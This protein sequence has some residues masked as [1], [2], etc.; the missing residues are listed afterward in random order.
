MGRDKARLRVD[1]EPLWRRQVRVLRDAGAGPVV[2]VQALGQRALTRQRNVRVLRDI[3]KNAG[4]L[5]GLQAALAASRADFVAVVAVD[6]PAIEPAWFVH[7]AQQCTAGRGVV[8]RS[9]RGYE[10]LAAIYPRC[11]LADAD[12]QLARGDYS[13]QHFVLALVRA[14]RLRVQRATAADRRQLVNWNAP[15]DLSAAMMADGA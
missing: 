9:F 14:R 1:G 3:V 11:A 5:A 8:I 15:A 6:L 12:A 2:L 10:P 7:L 13:L 4:P